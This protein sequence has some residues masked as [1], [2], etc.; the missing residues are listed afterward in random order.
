MNKCSYAKKSVNDFFHAFNYNHI[1]KYTTMKYEF[2]ISLGD[3]WMLE[4]MSRENLTL[5]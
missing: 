1:K 3:K 2:V 5:Q 4:I